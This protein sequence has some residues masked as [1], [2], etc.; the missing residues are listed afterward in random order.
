MLI[1][2]IRLRLHINTHINTQSMKIA[3]SKPQPKYSRFYRPIA[4][5][6]SQLQRCSWKPW[7]V[8]VFQHCTLLQVTQPGLIRSQLVSRWI[9]APLLSHIHLEAL[10]AAWWC[11]ECAESCPVH[12]EQ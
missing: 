11:S 8:L 2:H 9:P 1:T 6:W 12:T 5:V 3:Y 10:S 7:V 4:A